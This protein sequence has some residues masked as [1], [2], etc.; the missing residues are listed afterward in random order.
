[1]LLTLI[2]DMKV[3]FKKNLLHRTGAQEWGKKLD[4]LL[5]AQD[6]D[7]R[8]LGITATPKR[9]MDGRNM[10]DEIALKLGYTEEQVKNGEHIAKKMDLIDAI[11]LGIVVNPRIVECEYNLKNDTERWENLLEKIKGMDDGPEKDEYIKKY[12]ELRKKLGEAKE[13]PELF[14]DSITKKD[15]RYIFY[16]PIGSNE[17]VEDEDGNAITK[18]SGEEKVKESMEQ[19]REWLKYVDAEPEFYS[20]LGEYGNSKNAEQLDK[21]EKSN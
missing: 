14:R 18:K 3:R 2:V 7:L 13:I 20:M 9:D 6:D 10:S 15:G 5:D 16:M 17:Y 11:R 12:E 19:L 8:V 1:M 4:T 21:F